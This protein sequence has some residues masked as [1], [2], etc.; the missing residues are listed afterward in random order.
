MGFNFNHVAI[1]K[2]MFVHI[3]IFC[4]TCSAWQYLI[5]YHYMYGIVFAVSTWLLDIR[6]LLG[7]TDVYTLATQAG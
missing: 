3:V 1:C 2:G 5:L 6:I 7:K 4:Y